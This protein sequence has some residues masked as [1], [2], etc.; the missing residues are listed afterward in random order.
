MH[1]LF[2]FILYPLSL[3]PMP[4]L[5]GIAFLFYLVVRYVIGYRKEIITNNLKKSFPEKDDKEIRQLRNAYYRHLARIAAEML[6]MLTMSRRNVMR[7]YRC[8]NPELVNRFYEEGK[9]VILMS[10]H[11]NNWEWMILSLPMQY[12]H[13]GVGVGK[14]NSNKAFEKLIN[15]ARTRNGTEVVFADH[16]REVFERCELGH[17]PAAYMM[18][19]DQ[20]P[21]NVHKSYRTTFLNQPSAMI[22]GAEHFAKKYDIPVIYYEVIQE[23]IGHYKIVNHLITEHPTETEYGEITEAYV[24]HLEDTIRNNP[25]YWLWSHRRWKLRLD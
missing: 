7:R 1:F 10:A 25:P 20:S 23:K 13:H 2:Y 4:L 12:H 6:K 24:R 11:Y 16:V 3:L 22:Y 17:T 15:R 19:S 5:Y 8:E 9:S 14:A 21:N 18:L